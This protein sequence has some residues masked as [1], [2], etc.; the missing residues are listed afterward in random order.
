MA[1]TTSVSSLAS[2]ATPP[3]YRVY[4]KEAKYDF[5]K[6]IRMPAYAL[7]TIL[8]PV[9][10]Y[11]LFGILLASRQPGH[12]VQMSTYLLATYG[13]FGVIGAALFSFGVGVATERGQGWL[14]VK[15]A[16]PMP[17]TAYFFAKV[18]TCMIFSLV[19]AAC[20]I[21]LGVFFG[22]VHITA[23]MAASLSL[24]LVLG[25]IP[26]CAIGLAIGYLAGPNSAVAVVNLIYLPAG[27]C[28]GLWIPLEFLP[29]FLQRVAYQLPPYHLG[30]LA[31][32][33]VGYAHGGHIL[34]HVAELV[35]TTIAALVIARIAYQ[36]DAGKLY[37]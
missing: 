25:S 9:M 6:M 15:R 29:H 31:L 14:Q 7:P 13:A 2:H 20:L 16:S 35:F 12:S 36:R 28:S 10:F 17:P 8:F 21:L 11:V 30:R 33:T 37:G 18:V 19:I 24:V 26:F 1:T 23:T 22:N 4:L 27:F 3:R 34:L 32:A 5:L